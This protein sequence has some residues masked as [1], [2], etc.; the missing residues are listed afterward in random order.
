MAE[1]KIFTGEDPKELEKELNAFIKEK[2][3]QREHTTI[4]QSES[5]VALFAPG[6]GLRYIKRNHTITL[7]H[8]DPEKWQ[9][10]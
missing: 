9:L 3:W 2:K 7:F 1:F 5:T 8:E 10:A 4:K 6:E